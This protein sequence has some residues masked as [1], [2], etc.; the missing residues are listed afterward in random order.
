MPQHENNSSNIEDWDSGMAL[1]LLEC[2]VSTGFL[3][4]FAHTLG[5]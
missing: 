5:G 4:H 2:Y 1:E 3:E